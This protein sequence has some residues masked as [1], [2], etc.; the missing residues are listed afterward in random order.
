MDDLR[1]GVATD[2]PFRERLAA[3]WAN[4]FTALTRGYFLRAGRAG[5]V[6]EAIRPHL[7]GRFA[8]MLFAVATHPFMLRY[9]DQRVSI[10]P[11]SPV[12]LRRDRGLNENYARELLEL[13]TLGV[14][15]GYDQRDVRQLAELLTGLTS[16]KHHTDFAFRPDWAEPGPEEVLGKRYGGA[17]PQLDDIRTVLEDLALHPSTARHLARKLAAHFLADDPDEDMV[18]QMASAYQSSGGELMALYEAMLAHPLAWRG[19]GGKAKTPI[20]F[21]VTAMRALGTTPEQLDTFDLGRVRK[22]LMRPMVLMGQPY[23]RPPGPD[24]WADEV[25]AWI[26]PHGLAARIGLA[27][28]ILKWLKKDQ[29][30][31]RSFVYD[32]LADA[33]GIALVQ[34]VHGAETRAEGLMLVLASPEFNRR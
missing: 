1:R 17:A 29:L 16:N 26:T 30:D 2:D 7:A 22:R 14:G 31:P 34:A 5:Y 4:H 8:D 20:E 25:P 12:G 10:G 28:V 24:G 32:A 33:P 3:F 21:L 23:A 6:A 11:N 9:L 19:F 15:G 18:A 27:Q 13:H